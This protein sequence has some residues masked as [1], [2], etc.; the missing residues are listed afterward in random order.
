MALTGNAVIDTNGP[1]GGDNLQDYM[2]TATAGEFWNEPVWGTATAEVTLDNDGE[3]HLDF[4]VGMQPG[5]NY[6]I[7][8]SLFDESMYEDA[9]TSDPTADAYLGPELAQSGAAPATPPLTVWRRLWVEND[10]MEAIPLDDLGFKK[11]A[12]TGDIADPRIV[13]GF[14]SSTMDSTELK[15]V[16]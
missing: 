5:N 12:L 7:V 14:W 6:R 10:S 2:S 4:R 15:Y 11:S 9:Q 3:A 8:A 1:A 13:H 16:K